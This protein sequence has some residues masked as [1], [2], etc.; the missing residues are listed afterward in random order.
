MIVTKNNQTI[1]IPIVVPIFGNEDLLFIRN[2]KTIKLTY[3]RISDYFI[4]CTLD[5]DLGEW[6]YKIGDNVGLVQIEENLETNTSYDSILPVIEYNPTSDDHGGIPYDDLK[7]ITDYLYE[8]TY[9][10]K[11]SDSAIN[12]YYRNKY[13]PDSF[14]GCTTFRKLTYF[15]RNFDWYYSDYA[16]FVIHSRF[17]GKNQV[18]GMG[19][20]IPALT[21]EI[22]KNRDWDAD[23]EEKYKFLPYNLVDGVNDKHLAASVMTV[24]SAKGVTTGTNPGKTD[25]CMMYII[26]YI[27]QNHSD[28]YTACCDIRDNFNVYAP[29]MSNGETQEFHF[30]VA[31]FRKSYALEFVN[32]TTVI[33]DI[34]GRDIMTNFHLDGV[35]FDNTAYHYPIISTIETYGQGVERYR[36]I[37]GTY[38]ASNNPWG[39]AYT[40]NNMLKNCR[41]TLAYTTPWRTEFCG[42]AEDLTVYNAFNNPSKFNTIVSNARTKYNNRTRTDEEKTWHT[43]HTCIYN[44]TTGVLELNIQEDFTTTYTFNCTDYGELEIETI[45]GFPITPSNGLAKWA[46]SPAQTNWTGK[47]HMTTDGHCVLEFDGPVGRIPASAFNN[48]STAGADNCSRIKNIKF[49]STLFELG[50]LAFYDQANWEEVNLEGFYKFARS[51]QGSQVWQNQH[52]NKGTKKVHI[53]EFPTLYNS[54]QFINLFSNMYFLE[55]ISIDRGRVGGSSFSGNRRLKKI[56]LGSEVISVGVNAFQSSG[57]AYNGT[58]KTVI[59]YN[60]TPPTIQSNSF[61]SFNDFDIYVPAESVELYKSAANWNTY[62]TRIYPLTQ[63]NN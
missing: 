26:S 29:E 51:G 5:L 35:E 41:Y 7:D 45:D 53:D 57:A 10:K 9:T 62:A 40:R 55:E 3:T 2:Q 49:P 38:Y 52:T 20:N 13:R 54:D 4:S 1:K 17:E 6:S 58:L 47:Y 8:I 36:T 19:G 33:I 24:P 63:L 32:N 18:L 60:T 34:T 12:D 11:L 44:I 28:A 39:V 48:G 16:E 50:D 61:S 22:V 56:T 21:D 23:I 43:E 31:D 27:L 25:M 14:G 46:V 42:L 15:A 30:F 37:C 59:S